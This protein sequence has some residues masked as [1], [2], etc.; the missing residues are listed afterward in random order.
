MTI[1]DR[2]VAPLQAKS[3]EMRPILMNTAPRYHSHFTRIV[4]LQSK[5]R[6]GMEEVGGVDPDQVHPKSLNTLDES[7]P[8]GDRLFCHGLSRDLLWGVEGLPIYRKHQRLPYSMGS[9]RWE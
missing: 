1:Q 9:N 3:N 8:R 4:P 7:S 5:M 2:A 6:N